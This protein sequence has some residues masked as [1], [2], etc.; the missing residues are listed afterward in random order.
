[1]SLRANRG[2]LDQ[3]RPNRGGVPRRHYFCR[4][5]RACDALASRPT[6]REEAMRGLG[7][8]LVGSS[9]L[10][11]ALAMPI[12][13]PAQAAEPIKI[14]FGMGLTGGLAAMGKAAVLAMKI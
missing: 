2:N 10:A 8:L 9:L 1:M 5:R 7:R 12:A 13:R 3:P 6:N 4:S 14:G 11:A